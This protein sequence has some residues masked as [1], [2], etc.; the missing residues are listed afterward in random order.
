MGKRK[1]K[2]AKGDEWKPQSLIAIETNSWA[3]LCELGRP[4]KKKRNSNTTPAA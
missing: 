4:K 3:V 2:L 1:A